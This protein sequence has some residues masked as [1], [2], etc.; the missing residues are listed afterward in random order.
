MRRLAASALRR[1]LDVADERRRLDERTA[2]ATKIAL[3]SLFLDYRQLVEGGAR[4]PS[5]WETGFRV[6]SQFDEDGVILFLLAVAGPGPRKFVELGAGDGVFASNCANLAVNLGFH[7]LFAEAREGQ[8]EVGRRFYARHPDTKDE[9]PVFASAFLTREN[10][11]DIVR[12]AGL[13]GEIDLLSIDVDGND[14][15]LWEALDCVSPRFVVIETHPKL[16]L[17][18]DYVM[19]YEPRFDVASMAPGTRVGASPT[20]MTR[21]AERLGYR[22]VGANVYG[23]NVFY[24]RSD[25]AQQLPTIQVRDLMRYGAYGRP[26]TN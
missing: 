19:P 7:G 13:E 20:A 9:P 17:H 16:G 3:R 6:F 2:P 26:P 22:L 18:E 25:V 10:V 1:V 12:S 11:N 14:Y 5:V 24:A 8:V 15:W 21:L 23:F 4:L